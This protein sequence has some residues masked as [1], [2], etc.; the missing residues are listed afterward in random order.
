[1]S[2]CGVR[3]PRTLSPSRSSPPP[4]PPPP[5]IN[6]YPQPKTAKHEVLLSMPNCK[7]HL[8]DEGEAIEL[9]SGD[10]KLIQISDDDIL[11]ATIIKINDDLQWPLTKD[12]PVDPLHYLFSL[13]L[14]KDEAP[15]SYGVTFSENVHGNFKLLDKFLKEHS[16]FSSSSSSRKADIDWKDFAPKVD[17]DNNFLAKAIA[18]GTGQ[19]IKGILLCSNAYTNQVQK[20]GNMILNQAMEQKN[21]ISRTTINESNKINGS[22]KENG[23]NKSLKSAR[24]LSRMTENM[25]K[26]MLNGVGIATG[27]VMGPMVRSQAGKT[28]FSMVPG[29]VLL[30]SLDAV[31]TVMDAVEAAQKQA[32]SATSGAVTRM[33][34]ERFGE[35]AGEATGDVLAT[36]GHV[37]GTAWNVAKIRKA[38]TPASSV[39]NGVRM[40][41]TKIR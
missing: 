9:A 5:T 30:A 19:I 40:N 8:M 27:S 24:N 12:E 17:A 7:V 26:A 14:I 34:G 28:F 21:G 23:I 6:N 2:C 25:S 33:V 15:L 22:R 3:K 37:A 32:L 29:E 31:N 4:M 16:T 35:S 11:L 38:I 39:S 18:E 1:M 41:V 36:A 20:G 10:F 13:R